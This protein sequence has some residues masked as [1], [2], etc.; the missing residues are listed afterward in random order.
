MV[1]WRRDIAVTGMDLSTMVLPRSRGFSPAE[2]FVVSSTADQGATGLTDQGMGPLTGAV[3]RL[4]HCAEA[5]VVVQGFKN[6]KTAV[7]DDL[8]CPGVEAGQGESHGRNAHHSI[9]LGPSWA[10]SRRCLEL[11]TINQQK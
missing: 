2:R 4:E 9:Q 3:H 5:L 10:R 8:K 7:K 1:V 6:Q 11:P